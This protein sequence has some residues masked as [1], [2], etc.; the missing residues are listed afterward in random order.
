MQRAAERRRRVLIAAV[1]FAAALALPHTA[2][3]AESDA[4]ARPPHDG[5][6][7]VRGTRHSVVEVDSAV[8]AATLSAATLTTA[9]DTGRRAVVT[10]PVR[11]DL[12][13]PDGGTQR[14]DVVDAPI[15]APAL[16][17][18]HPSI[19]TY[20]GI[21][22]DDTGATVRLSLSPAGLHAQVRSAHGDWYV[23]PVA[24]HDPMH[25]S[26]LGADLVDGHDVVEVGWIDAQG[27]WHDGHTESE[28]HSSAEFE[29]DLGSGADAGRVART[30][31]VVQLRTYR[32]AIST[33]AEY[34]RFHGDQ[35][36]EV[37][38]AVVAAVTRV[39]GIY[40]DELAITFQLVDGT[41]QL[42]FFDPAT[43][44]FTNDDAGAMLGQNQTTID[45]VI[46]AANYDIGHVFSTGGGGLAR[47]GSVAVDGI[48]AQGVTGSR[49]PIGDAFWVD[50]V[51]HEMG[52]QFGANHTFSGVA[53]SCSGGNA[54]A[55]SAVEPGSGTTIMAYAGIC[56]SDNLAR[57]SDPYF[58]TVSHAEIGAHVAQSGRGGAVTATT[59]RPPTVSVVG[60][61]RFVVPAN[62]PYVLTAR[63]R[64]V[65]GDELTYTWEQIDAGVLRSLDD[66]DPITSGAL[67][68]SRPPSTDR[69]RHI[70]TL[71]AIAAGRTNALSDCPA[72]PRGRAC[73]AE[74]LATSARTL[75][76]RVTAR[77]VA[78]PAGGIAT[79]V[80][81]V[82]VVDG[83]PF[84]VTSQRS[85]AALAPGSSVRVRWDVA[86][87]ATGAI[88]TPTVD[89]LVSVD[90]GASFPII[91]AADVPNDG[92]H[93]VRLPST[94]T[95]EVR[96]MVR[97]HGN[98]FFDTT[99]ADIALAVAPGAPRRVGAATVKRRAVVSWRAPRSD[100]F[101]RITS[102]VVRSSPD[103]LRCTTTGERRCVIRGLSRG[104][105][106]TF[107][108]RA[109]NA[110]GA[111]P[112]SRPSPPVMVR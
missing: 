77:D 15:M 105:E 12:P 47:I 22:V 96:L 90:G 100:G 54:R 108:V 85:P 102:Y 30:S 95:R 89:I 44:P 1:M 50:Y 17:A 16:A 3:T 38:A 41:D 57:R 31:E 35:T 92:A 93:R 73:W 76:F 39:A 28:A 32:L 71:A 86:G 110:V 42:I 14:F 58:H 59:N 106:H 61:T 62:T 67:V 87:T 82:R 88:D 52:H 26:Y 99:D 2:T 104:V 65:D 45:T 29:A 112:R 24:P 101:S 64:D 25:I 21:G 46:G 111:G 63:G 84:A 27:R 7:T 107:T 23:D 34:S 37:M 48:K 49:I 109:R 91:V 68:R 55:A 103:R 43:D 18:R 20:R 75:R 60:G 11:I 98:I 9:G 78:S 51:A 70:P 97:G 83:R 8:L 81:S 19:T 10:V 80:A 4:A 56:E 94:P 5:T 72:L 69:R 79:A 33:T 53:G 13:A 40:E 74:R 6:I 36:T 66:P